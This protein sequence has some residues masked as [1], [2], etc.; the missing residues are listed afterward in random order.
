MASFQW[1]LKSKICDL[2]LVASE[3]GLE[4]IHWEKDKNIPL[5]K[6][7]EDKQP[8][9][10]IL[11]KA[12]RQLEEYFAG[13]RTQ[14]DLPLNPS[15]TDF[16]QRVWMELRKIPYGK[17]CSYKEI[18]K[19]IKNEKAVRAV[20][21]ANGKNPFSIIVPCHRVISANGTL[22]GYAGG[23]SIKEKLLHHETSLTV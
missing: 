20:G 17:T 6:S 1:K 16:Q 23:L 4:A 5:L 2:Y 11:A 10:K 14:F 22:G 12:A 8:Q 7:L 15:G 21:T 19:R 18:A 3:A 9:A 13:K